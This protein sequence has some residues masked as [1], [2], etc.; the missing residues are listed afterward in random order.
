M[1]QVLVAT[2]EPFVEE[3]QERCQIPYI[4]A[5]AA[6]AAADPPNIIHKVRSLLSNR[7]ESED[8]K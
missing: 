7:A 1:T 4:A 3:G 8:I 2:L 5:A 6:A